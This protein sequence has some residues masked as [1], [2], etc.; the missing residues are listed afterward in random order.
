MNPCGQ[1]RKRGR[2]RVAALLR[3]PALRRDAREEQGLAKRK[4]FSSS[5]GTKDPRCASFIPAR[6]LFLFILFWDASRTVRQAVPDKA[7][8]PL[9]RYTGTPNL[10]P[11]LVYLYVSNLHDVS[12]S[13]SKIKY[14]KKKYSKILYQINY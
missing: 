13:I 3:D 14:Y 6:L 10:L 4:Y 8:A 12:L 2:T 11:L 5:T 7:K 9:N 1:E